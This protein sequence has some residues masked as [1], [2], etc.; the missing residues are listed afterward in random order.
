VVAANTFLAPVL[1]LIG[2]SLL[3]W[4]LL[5]ARRIPAMQAAKIAPDEAKNPH[6]G[7]KSKVPLKAEAAAHNYNH[8]MEQPTI[9]YALMFYAMLTGNTVSWV[10]YLAWAYVGV[11]VLHSLVQVS[12]GP[13]MVRFPLFVLSTLCLFGMIAVMVLA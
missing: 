7:W 1:V 9:F 3:I 2:W 6:S 13:V 5:Y 10:Y 12:T 8:L 11:R 4:I